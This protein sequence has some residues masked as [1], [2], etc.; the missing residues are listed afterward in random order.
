MA[1]KTKKLTDREKKQIIAQKVSGM[2]NVDIARL[3]G[4][5]E[6]SVRRVLLANKDMAAMVEQKKEQN[7]QEMLAYFDCR[8][9]KAQELLDRIIDALGDP[10]KLARANVRDLA[11]AYGIIADKFLAAQPKERDEVLARA[12]EILG[13]ISGAIK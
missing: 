11:T 7:T 1:K 10:E 13:G 6:T 2:T 12:V 8:R 4:I 9:G 5:S 3:H